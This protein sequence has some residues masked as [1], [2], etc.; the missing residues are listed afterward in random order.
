MADVLPKRGKPFEESLD[1][2]TADDSKEGF[3]IWCRVAGGG[4]SILA[5][6]NWHR[7]GAVDRVMEKNPDGQIRLGP[8]KG[9]ATTVQARL[10]LPCRSEAP[11]GRGWLEVELMRWDDRNVPRE[12]RVPLVQRD[13]DAARLT[14]LTAEA[15]RHLATFLSCE[16]A[17]LLAG[18]PDMDWLP[19][20]SGT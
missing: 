13:E 2:D 1:A 9:L 10:F 15:A 19:T 16:G 3:D 8:A 18:T 7:V 17:P 5:S 6:Y 4:E 12:E 20:A 14:E 11:E